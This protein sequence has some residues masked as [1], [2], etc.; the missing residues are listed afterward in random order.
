MT[1]VRRPPNAAVI[2]PGDTADST[3]LADAAAGSVD[4][5]DGVVGGVDWLVMTCLPS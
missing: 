4:V 3:L 1:A 2:G 5:V